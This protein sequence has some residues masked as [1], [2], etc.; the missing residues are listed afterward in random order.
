M[1]SG[2]VFG[3][4]IG[5]ALNKEPGSLLIFEYWKFVVCYLV[6]FCQKMAEVKF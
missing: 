1:D 5:K 6:I 3:I 2:Q 4:G